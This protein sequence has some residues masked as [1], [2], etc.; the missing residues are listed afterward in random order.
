[1]SSTP[2]YLQSLESLS[3]SQLR[4]LLTEHLP[5]Q[6]LGL[7]LESSAIERD[8]ALNANIVLPRLGARSSHGLDF[9]R[10]GKHQSKAH[11]KVRLLIRM[12]SFSKLGKTVPA[13]ARGSI[14]TISLN[15]RSGCASR[16]HLRLSKKLQA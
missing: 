2:D 8:A 13:W 6:K 5:K 9:N 11:G 3:A 4:R 10:K 1:M 16:F 7:Y 14:L 12:L 15:C